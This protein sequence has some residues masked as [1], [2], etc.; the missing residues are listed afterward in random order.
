M[1]AHHLFP[2]AAEFAP[3]WAEAGINIEAFRVQLTEGTHLGQL[4]SSGGIPGIGRGGLWNETWRRYFAE[5]AA[6]GRA[7]TREGLFHQLGQMVSDFNL[8]Y[9]SPLP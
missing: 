1:Q 4:H 9:F 7:V 8:P 6:A 5:E 2:Q 3:K